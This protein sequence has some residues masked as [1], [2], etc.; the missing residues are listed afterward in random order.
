MAVGRPARLAVGV[1]SAGRVGAVLGAALAAAGHHVV[2]TSGVSRDSVRR[3][4]ALLPGVPLKSPDDVVAGVDLALL[5]VPDD[6]LP[7]L[8]RGFAAAGC[9]RPGQ[10]V[11]HT[12]GAHGVGVLA[13]AVEH[14]VLPLALHPV[15]TFTGRAEDVARLAGACVG[16]TATEGDEVGWS[17]GEA[18][19]VEMGAE[20]VRVPEAV[21]PLYHAALAHGANHLVTLVRDCADLLERAGVH[22]AERLIAPLL[23]AALDNALRH[24]DRALTGPV[25]R[26]DAGTVAVHLRELDAA[27]PDLARTYRALATRT[28]HRARAAGLLPDH[29]AQDVLRTLQEDPT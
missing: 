7:G 14:G 16:V 28:A 27:D 17:V 10:I 9:F 12:S 25:A 18:L 24:G 26:G 1:V 2:A 20:P 8:V 4:E 11:V 21:R 15:L 13:P 3:A 19:V 23:S 6:V 5:A 29:A 22:P